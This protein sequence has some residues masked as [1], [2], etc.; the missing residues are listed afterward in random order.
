LP[1]IRRDPGSFRDPR[2]FVFEFE[3]TIYRGVAE[4]AVADLEMLLASATYER[5]LARGAIVETAF[6]DDTALRGELPAGHRLARHTRIPFISYPYEWPFDLLKRAALLHLDIQRDALAQ[7]MSLSDASAYNIQFRGVDPVFIDVL[8]F[9]KYRDG[10]IWPG[11]RQFLMQFLNPLLMSS[12]AGIACHDWYR[13]SLEGIESADLARAIPWH[14]KL[15]FNVLSH[16]VVPSRMDRRVAA[17]T[18][19]AVREAA[20]VR[21]PKKHYAGLLN[22][23]R[24]WVAGLE[25]KVSVKSTWQDYDRHNTYDDAERA[26]KRAFVAKFCGHATPG[27]L[28]DIGCNTG[29]YSE[30]ALASGAK[31]AIGLDFDHGALANA[32]RRAATK[33]LALTPLVQNAM[34]PSPGQGWRGIERKPM[35]DRTRFDAVLALAVLHHLT[36]ARNV[37]LDDAVDWL[38]GWAPTGV[39]EFVPK[40]DPTVQTMLSLRGDIFE[41]YSQEAFEVC[42]AKRATVVE[43]ETVSSSQRVL[44]AFERI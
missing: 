41:S 38:V 18:A 44:Y 34:N 25:P 40:S 21:L 14:R 22:Q 13:G 23:L 15:S 24:D 35:Q 29:E 1:P 6:V 7:G 39:I 10:E 5:L 2:G 16:V 42:L 43:R 30:T 27:L 37:P 12:L 3:G 4:D 9:R 17:N 20:K 28:V 33:Q 11:Q 36:I 19:Q 26:A 32:C 8:S 31:R